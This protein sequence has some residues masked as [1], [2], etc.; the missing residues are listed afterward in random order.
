V[1]GRR[2]VGRKADKLRI[3]SRKEGCLEQ[4]I[5]FW[6]KEYFLNLSIFFWSPTFRPHREEDQM[7]VVGFFENSTWG[8]VHVWTLPLP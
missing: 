7:K 8:A 4:H 6:K 5:Y 2:N 1:G 3:N